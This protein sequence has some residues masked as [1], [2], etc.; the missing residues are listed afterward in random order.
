MS[1][2]I[3]AIES[4]QLNNCRIVEPMPAHVSVDSEITKQE[5]TK[6]YAYEIGVKFSV[7]RFSRSPQIVDQT[8]YIDAKRALIEDIFGEFRPLLMQAL[9]STYER[10]FVATRDAIYKIEDKMFREGLTN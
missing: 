9:H 8:T 4:H 3:K 6:E 5:Y 2:V 1:K 7:K 10:D